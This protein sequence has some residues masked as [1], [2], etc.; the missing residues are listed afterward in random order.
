MCTQSL[1]GSVSA[2]TEMTKMTRIQM[3]SLVQ[4][5]SSGFISFLHWCTRPL[6][7]P[8]SLSS[9]IS[10]PLSHIFFIDSEC[11]MVSRCIILISLTRIVFLGLSAWEIPF[12]AFKDQPLP[13][14]RCIPWRTVFLTSGW[15]AECVCACVGHSPCSIMLYYLHIVALCL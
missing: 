13:H 14:S 12:P 8:L 15:T 6:V 4:P 5:R 2:I 3:W 9:L 7:I 11:P 1:F 10:F